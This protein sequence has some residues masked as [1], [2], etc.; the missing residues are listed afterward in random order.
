MRLGDEMRRD[1]AAS[2]RTSDATHCR[3]E[4]SLPISSA[5]SDRLAFSMSTKLWRPRDENQIL[6]IGLFIILSMAALTFFAYFFLGCGPPIAFFLSFINPK[7]F[8]TLLTF[9]RL[10]SP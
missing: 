2:V 9:F 7:A 10:D 5:F 6:R 1:E 8:L 4:R 3:S